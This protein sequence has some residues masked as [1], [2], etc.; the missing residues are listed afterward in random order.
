MRIFR[1]YDILKIYKIIKK[2]SWYNIILEDKYEAD[3]KILKMMYF[4]YNI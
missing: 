1:I 3:D 4:H 2:C